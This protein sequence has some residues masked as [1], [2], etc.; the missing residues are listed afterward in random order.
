MPGRFREQRF[1]IV[2]PGCFDR[3][4]RF[5]SIK[6]ITLP[7]ILI[8]LF[9][10]IGCHTGIIPSLADIERS[11]VFLPN[12][13]HLTPVGRSLRVGDLP[14]N[15]AVNR[16]RRRIAVTNNGK[17]DQSIELIDGENARVIDSISLRQSWLGL[18]FSDDDRRLYVSGGNLNSIFVFD[19]SNDKL[20]LEDSIVLGKPWPVKISP[21]GL[22]L[23]DTRSRLYVVT[24]EDSSLYII[25]RGTK[26]I[27]RKIAL[28]AEAY[29]CILSPTRQTLY[30]SLWGTDK[31]VAYDT[32]MDT[33]RA[34]I[35][36]GDH[37]NDLC[38]TSDGRYLFAAN[39]QDNSVS[40]IDATHFTVL[41]TLD[42]A[43]YPHSLEGS[44]TN[45][46]ALSDD[47]GTLYIAN[48]DNNCLAVFDVRHP[49]HSMSKGFI[50]TGWYPTCVRVVHNQLWIANG[51]GLTSLPNPKGP[52][53]AQR[54]GKAEDIHEQYIGSLFRGTIS[55]L[56]E[57]NDRQLAGYSQ[58]VYRNTPYK[59][60]EDGGIG[61]EPGN[62]VPLR[63]GD[64]S[65]ITHVFYVIKEN[66]TYD[67]VLA[68]DPRGNGD[69][70]L[71][72]FPER[73]T[74]NEHALAREFVLL[75]NFYVD[76]EVS[77]DGHN[78]STAAYANDYI[79]KTWPTRYGGRGGN[80]DYI[81]NRSIALPRAGFIWDNCTAH[82]IPFRNYG[83][84]A[85][86]GTPRLPVLAE[87]TCPAYPGWNLEI[88]DT[89]RERIWEHDFDSLLAVNAVPALS[90]VYLPNDHTSALAKG[91]FTPF[92]AVADNDFA[93]GKFV[94]H[95]SHSSLW[96]ESVVFV[97]EDDAQDGPDHVDAH[98]S[99]AFVVGGRV[100]RH[101]VDHT[102][103]STS[104][105][106]RTMELILGLPPMSQYDAAAGP[107]W[108]CFQEAVDGS[109]FQARP[110]HI[111][112]D[113]R[114][115]AETNLMKRSEGFDL[116][117]AD[118]VPS[119]EMNRILWEAV[120][121]EGSVI[122]P[123]RRGAFLRSVP[124]DD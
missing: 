12:G 9:G 96:K 101:A 99:I 22:A 68:D 4:F 81:G 105:M 2:R 112:L 113:D 98:R 7:S 54:R 24:K 61:R 47:D 25:D 79:E 94:E 6:V 67:Q 83:E 70:S 5:V 51:K 89:T 3:S 88:R 14:L 17:S 100:R 44:T 115:I 118:R 117:Q 21:T 31:I 55:V 35:Q 60:L 63:P 114:N 15:L 71:C 41:E 108:R 85:D 40:V 11:R 103:Y 34:R 86:E 10:G 18:Q 13:W 33:M 53:P 93:L 97:I 45:S 20:R 16:N 104:S 52:N 30:V 123:A 119:E 1:V 58:V 49:G 50:P 65:P 87:H 64:A 122:P 42:A 39:S 57:P 28:G 106:L 76:G 82:N 110:A 95:I 69:T 36:A 80:Y 107:M 72:L 27:L 92:A 120:R 78:W 43:L 109:A 23:D 37:P 48:A 91:A 102:L 32:E 62:P 56:A 84:F 19:V 124:G 46:I 90:I 29:T 73:I 26:S 59:K 116:S 77:A 66:R 75:D 8:L 74:P 38:L 111:N 121:G